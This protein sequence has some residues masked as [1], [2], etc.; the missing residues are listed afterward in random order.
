MFGFV[1]HRPAL[2]LALS[3]NRRRRKFFFFVMIREGNNKKKENKTKLPH[4]FS[5][6]ILKGPSFRGIM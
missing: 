4:G 6:A 3:F 1:H 2:K 5:G